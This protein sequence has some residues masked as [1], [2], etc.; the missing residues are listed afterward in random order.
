MGFCDQLFLIDQGNPNAPSVPKK[1]VSSPPA[2]EGEKSR[3]SGEL[4][5]SDAVM[6][7]VCWSNAYSW[8]TSKKITYSIRV[9]DHGLRE[10]KKVGGTSI[11]QRRGLRV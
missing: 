8:M 2:K 4:V 11:K 3:I 9:D 5:F 10:K 7:R 6:L 1:R